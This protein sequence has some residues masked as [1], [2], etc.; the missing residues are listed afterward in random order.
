[1]PRLVAP[2][3]LFGLV[4][5]TGSRL[6]LKPDPNITLSPSVCSALKLRLFSFEGMVPK[7]AIIHIHVQARAQA[8]VQAQF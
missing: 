3:L 5:Q 2:V 4:L 7:V 1:M 8:Q 6:N